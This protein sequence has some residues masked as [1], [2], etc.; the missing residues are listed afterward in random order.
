MAGASGPPEAPLDRGEFVEV[1]LRGILRDPEGP[2]RL[3]AAAERFVGRSFARRRWLLLTNKRLVMLRDRA[4]SSYGEADWYDVSVDRRSV[5]AGLPVVR[6]DICVVGLVWRG[7]QAGTRSDARQ[8]SHSLLVPA[9]V[10]REAER[11]ARSLGAR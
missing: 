4:P 8:G 3:V 9:T 1:A 10:Y 11:F 7:P 5:R 6:G 2:G